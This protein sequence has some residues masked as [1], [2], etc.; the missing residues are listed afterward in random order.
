FKET[1]DYKFEKPLE[2]LPF[3]PK[4]ESELALAN[5]LQ[6]NGLMGKLRSMKTAKIV[7]G[8]SG[9]LDSA[10]ALIVAHQAFKRLGRDPKDIIAVTLP[11]KITSH[12][13]KS[14]AINLMEGLG[15]TALEVPIEKDV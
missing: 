2:Q 5:E 6:I 7:V 12:E 10:L 3:I 13:T 1:S 9:G 11:T 15:V 14:D 8:I 4:D